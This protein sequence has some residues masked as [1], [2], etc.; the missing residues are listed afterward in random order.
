MN[1]FETLGL[2]IEPKRNKKKEEKEKTSLEM[3]RRK[4]LQLSAITGATLAAPPVLKYLFKEDNLENEETEHGASEE[5]SEKLLETEKDNIKSI[6]EIINFEKEGNIELNLETADALKNYWKKKYREDPRL[7]NSLINAYKKMGAWDSYLKKEFKEE[8][9]P[10]K[11]RYLLIPESHGIWKA[12][13]SAGAVGPYQFMPKT[14]KSYGLKSRYY[15]DCHPNIEERQDPI[16]SA[17]ACANLLKDL[18]EKGGQDWDLALSGYNGGYYW[19]Y[20]KQSREDRKEIN[21]EGFLKFLEEKINKIKRE[22]EEE[23]EEIEKRMDLK[24]LTYKIKK[25]DNLRK[26]AIKFRVDINELQ[27][28]NKIKD[29]RK[30]QIGQEIKIPLDEKNAETFKGTLKRRVE[31]DFWKKIKGF[32]ENLNYPPK[33]NAV[34]EL[35]KEG[36]VSEEEEKY[37]FNQNFKVPEKETDQIHYFKI[38]DQN[39][40][41]LSKKFSNISYKEIIKANPSLNVNNLREGDKIIIPKQKKKYTLTG[42]AKEENKSPKYLKKINPSIV[43]PNEEI[44]PGYKIRL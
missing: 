13:S 12:K 26:L 8:G 2:D 30:I 9:V 33:F 40:Y 24:T 32:S 39:I 38:S 31:D 5:E 42:I 29:P 11:F 16:K 20:L 10:E 17:G 27:S 23:K 34:Y 14:G 36:F 21:Y 44:P 43:N 19:K 28:F 3:N 22:K 7:K 35:I 4:F 41:R 6:K 18:Y 1:K 37:K 25:G 15:K